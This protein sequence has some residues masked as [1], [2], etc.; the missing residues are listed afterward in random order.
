MVLLIH[1]SSND[2][3]NLL[4]YY[5]N[6]RTFTFDYR[7]RRNWVNVFT[8]IFGRNLKENIATIKMNKF[9]ILLKKFFYTFSA[10]LSAVFWNPL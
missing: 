4:Q 5:V 8:T 2:L 1:S 7:Q 6:I 3:L 10:A 9:A